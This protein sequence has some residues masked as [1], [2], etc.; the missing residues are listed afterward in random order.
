MGFFCNC[1]A[2]KD[3][4]AMILPQDSNLCTLTSTTRI[5]LTNHYYGCLTCDMTKSNDRDICT[6]CVKKCH[7]DHQI[8]YQGVRNARCDCGKEKFGECQALVSS[9][10]EKIIVIHDG[11]W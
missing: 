11:K 4:A 7:K 10:G 3:C 2:K 9:N 6:S 5:L 1:G 8:T